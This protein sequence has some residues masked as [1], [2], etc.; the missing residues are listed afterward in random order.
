MLPYHSFFG[1]PLA[2]PNTLQLLSIKIQCYLS[3]L[4]IL[5]GRGKGD[6]EFMKSN[7]TIFQNVHVLR[8]I[9]DSIVVFQKLSEIL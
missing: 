3:D 9:F 2:F 7:A 5:G 8:H 1:Y 4:N 6:G